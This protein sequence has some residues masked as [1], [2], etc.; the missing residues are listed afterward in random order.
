MPKARAA[1][2][3]M[4]PMSPR[5]TTH[6]VEP[7]SRNGSV[8]C[9]RERRWQPTDP[10]R[11]HGSTMCVVGLGDIGRIVARAA[12]AFGMRVSGVSQRGRKVAEAGRVYRIRD[13]RKALGET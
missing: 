3:T 1:R 8:G 6:M 10:L 12:R 2:A 11:L 4:R 5:P 7:W 13:L 9:Q